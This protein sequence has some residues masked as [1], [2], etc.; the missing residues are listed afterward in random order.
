MIATFTAIGECR[1]PAFF[2]CV[3][4]YPSLCRGPAQI[5][6]R[7]MKN[8]NAIAVFP[9]HTQHANL[10]KP[11]RQSPQRAGSIA[12]IESRQRI[13]STLYSPTR[14]HGGVSDQTPPRPLPAEPRRS[15]QRNSLR[16]LLTNRSSPSCP[17]QQG[18]QPSCRS[19]SAQ[20]ASDVQ[21]GSVHAVRCQSSLKCL[22]ITLRQTPINA[23]RGKKD[24]DGQTDKSSSHRKRPERNDRYGPSAPLL[25]CPIQK[26]AV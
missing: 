5:H 15:A 14:I 12:Q 11:L 23:R 3:I 6:Q 18:R 19:E 21:H 1:R 13:A 8:I 2:I 17:R 16:S 24:H 7:Q 25:L 26:L 10:V 22:T 4:S 9:D 20:S